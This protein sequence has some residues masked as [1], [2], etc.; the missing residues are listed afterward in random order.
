MMKGELVSFVDGAEKDIPGWENT[1]TRSWKSKTTWSHFEN[2]KFF[3]M[4]ESRNRFAMGCGG[5]LPSI[6]DG[7]VIKGQ[8]MDD[9]LCS[10]KVLGN[11]W[12]GAGIK[13]FQDRETW[14]DLLLLYYWI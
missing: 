3:N 2:Y 9:I 5:Y 8:V 6:K 1:W 4:A 12:R 14:L 11:L 13:G 10:T 7:E